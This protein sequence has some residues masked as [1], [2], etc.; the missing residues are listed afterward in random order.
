MADHLIEHRQFNSWE[1]AE[2]KDCKGHKV[3]DSK[4]VFTYKF[5]ELGKLVKYKARIV[6]RG[7]Q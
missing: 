3:L 2:S 5:D 1:D 6:A 4:W 7:D